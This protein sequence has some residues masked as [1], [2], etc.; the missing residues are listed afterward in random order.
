[1]PGSDQGGYAGFTDQ[2]NNHYVATFGTAALTSLISV[3]L[4]CP[5]EVAAHKLGARGVS[6]GHVPAGM[7]ALYNR[8]L[9]QSRR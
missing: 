9:L 6:D 8:R 5:N 4:G 3:P 1:M 7:Q 2:V